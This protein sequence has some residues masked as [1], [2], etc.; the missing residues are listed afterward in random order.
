MRII[1]SDLEFEHFLNLF[2]NL[3]TILY[4]P[5]T[6]ARFS[7]SRCAFRNSSN[8]LLA[9]GSPVTSTGAPAPAP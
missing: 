8:F 6:V 5:S 7:P 3:L 4:L 2:I 9:S 1:D